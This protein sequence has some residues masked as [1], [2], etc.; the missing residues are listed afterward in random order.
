MKAWEAEFNKK[1]DRLVPIYVGIVRPSNQLKDS[2]T[3]LLRKYSL[4]QLTSTS[5]PI[6]TT[7]ATSINDGNG[8]QGVIIHYVCLLL[9]L[10]IVILDH[11]SNTRQ[12]VPE[13]GQWIHHLFPHVIELQ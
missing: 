5:A 6:A 2:Q 11:Q 9:L 8:K 4:V 1:H 13:S 7:A 10:V 12:P 3:D